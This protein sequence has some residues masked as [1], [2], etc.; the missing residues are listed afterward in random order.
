[1]RWLMGFAFLILAPGCSPPPVEDPEISDVVAGLSNGTG[2]RGGT[3]TFDLG[4][5]LVHGQTL[6]HTFTLENP[7]KT[8]VR[9]LK[10][11]A[12]KPCCSAV[13]AIQ[14]SIPPGGSAQVP[15]RYKPGY[16]GGLDHVSFEVETDSATWPVLRLSLTA[17][18]YLDW[19]I[20]PV[21]TESYSVPIG[22]MGQQTL[23]VTCRR[24][25][26]EGL[27][28]P[29]EVVTAK[30]LSA[31]WSEEVVRTEPSDGLVEASR[32]LRLTLPASATTGPQRGELSFQWASG[33]K[34]LY[35]VGWMVS[36]L[37]RAS[38]PGLVLEQADGDASRTVR[39]VSAKRP[40][41]VKSVTCPL[42]A[43]GVELPSEPRREHLLRIDL[44]TR[45]LAPGKVSSLEI[46]TDDPDQPQLVLSILVVPPTEQDS[47]HESKIK[48][49][50]LHAD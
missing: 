47:S 21:A 20:Q 35:T 34:K 2:Q 17:R 7:T 44:S 46:R 19:E 9:L 22:R 24:G 33:L 30:P 26:E 3:Q 23:R 40:F 31:H 5:V 27:A 29:D 38:P 39:L 18:L 11:V 4:A 14:D 15:V 41:R 43:K 8:T 49:A 42:L 16:Q 25:R 10:A 45:K 28:L 12:L 13:G 1:M 6:T 48:E 36:P 37:I 32:E 50:R